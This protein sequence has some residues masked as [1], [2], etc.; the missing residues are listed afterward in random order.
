MVQRDR[1]S[2]TQL[3]Q[4]SSTH[5]HVFYRT[6]KVRD[7][8]GCKLE[9]SN[10]D[11]TQLCLW[12]TLLCFSLLPRNHFSRVDEL[13]YFV[14][15]HWGDIMD[16]WVGGKGYRIFFLEIRWMIHSL[17]FGFNN[18]SR[19]SLFGDKLMSPRLHFYPGSRNSTRNIWMKHQHLLL[20]LKFSRVLFWEIFH[21][22]PGQM[23]VKLKPSSV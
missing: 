19:C 18:A 7:E 6:I 4:L 22:S 1:K 13:N 14:P 17:V 16:F 15:S 10:S 20:F 9:F 8:C 2:R 3:K 11:R 12:D 21:Y 5:T 23:T